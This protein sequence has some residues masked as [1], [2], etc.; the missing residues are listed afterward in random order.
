[1]PE[2]EERLNRSMPGLA[3]FGGYKTEKKTDFESK[4]SAARL[5]VGYENASI[6]D[7]ESNVAYHP[8]S[9]ASGR[10]SRWAKT[11]VEKNRP[12]NSIFQ[13]TTSE[14]SHSFQL[15]KFR[16]TNVLNGTL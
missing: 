11:R 8:T 2:F 15:D 4:R 5:G 9:E 7:G 1:V 6:S 14:A 13:N 12:L 10:T 3:I 16:L